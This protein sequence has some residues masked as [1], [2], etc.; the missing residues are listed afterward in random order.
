[1]NIKCMIDSIDAGFRSV[2]MLSS[3]VQARVLR[4]TVIKFLFLAFYALSKSIVHTIASQRGN[5]IT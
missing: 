3:S 5:R 4:D 1:M 2:H